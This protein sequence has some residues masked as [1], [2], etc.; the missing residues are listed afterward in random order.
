MILII[1]LLLLSLITLGYKYQRLKTFYLVDKEKIKNQ[2]ELKETL[3]LVSLEA[4]EKN[5][6]SLY[7]VTQR[8]SER[9]QKI[10]S[11]M[12]EK[13]DSQIRLLEKERKVDQ[14][15]MKEQLR[16]LLESEC[17]LRGETSKLSQAL[18]SPAGKGRWGEIQ[19]RRVVELAGMLQHCDFF[20]QPLDG[21]RRRPDLIV[22]LS[23]GRQVI[24][25]AKAP[26]EAYLESIDALEEP[27]RLE[28]FRHHARLVKDHI[29]QLGKKNYWEHFQPTPEFVILFLPSEAIFSAAIER[30]PSLIEYGAGQGV[31]LATPTT[32]IALLR[33]IAYGWKQESLSRYAHKVRELGDELYK[34]IS[35]LSTHWVN[36][37]KALGNAVECYNQATGSLEKKVLSTARKFGELGTAS[38]IN[39]IKELDPI[40]ILPRNLVSRELKKDEDQCLSGDSTER[41]K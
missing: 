9:K 22:R 3:R 14:G 8:D 13:I 19:L 40:E 31:M 11:E 33:A 24:I 10:L 5:Q 2:E 4:L 41:T 23:G 17:Q 6:D 28:K 39:S 34:R 29:T 35:D 37:G 20:D 21:H 30:D 16:A 26:L 12:V 32:L 18:R 7:E 1:A 25:D 38:S 15:A 36:A 27:L